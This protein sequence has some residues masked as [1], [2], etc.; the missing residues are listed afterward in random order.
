V[1]STSTSWDESPAVDDAIHWAAT[2]GRGGK[3]CSIFAAAGND[4]SGWYF[5]AISN[6]TAGSHSFRFEYSKDSFYSEGEDRVWLDDVTFP[7]VGR[8]SFEGAGFPPLGWS[9][10][11]YASW[12]RCTRPDRVR[13][14]GISS[15]QSGTIGNSQY[16]YLQVTKTISA[17]DVTFYSWTSTEADYDTLDVYVDGAYQ[18]SDPGGVNPFTL[19]VEFPARHPDV[20]AVGASTDFGY[21]S[22][23]SQFGTGLDLVA[24]SSGGASKIYTTDRTGTAGYNTGASPGG[25]YYAGFGGTSAA[26]PLAAGIGALVLSVNCDLTG[27]AVGEILRAAASKIGQVSYAS[28]WNSYYGYGQVDAFQAVAQAIPSTVLLDPLRTNGSF[29]VS[30]PTLSCKRY[31]L[32]YKDDWTQAGWTS[33][34]SIGGNGAVQ[35]LIDPAANSAQR[36]YR[37]LVQ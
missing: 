25:D 24:P 10:G 26:T 18:F 2:Q 5:F 36:F 17:G 13:G 4:G 37:V 23:Y 11:G 8:E 15:A 28:G 27:E 35:A 7:G 20:L 14:T 19:G 3:G 21:R 12:T 30:L 32:Q 34:P 6:L 1:I 33:L 9:T 22:D 31:V 29:R 16:T